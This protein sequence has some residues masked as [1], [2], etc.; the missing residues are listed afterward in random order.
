MPDRYRYSIM[1]A[2]LFGGNLSARFPEGSNGVQS[3]RTYDPSARSKAAFKAAIREAL[4]ELGVKEFPFFPENTHVKIVAAFAISDEAKD[5]D[6][7]MKHLKDAFTGVI[8][9]D[10]RWVCDEQAKKR[11]APIQAQLMEFSVE[12]DVEIL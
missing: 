5:S 12:E 1:L 6:N 8:Y 9:S 7:L 2:T 10:D 4:S 3:V 11:A